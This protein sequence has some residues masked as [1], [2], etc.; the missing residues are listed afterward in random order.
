[1]RHLVASAA[2]VG[3]ILSLVVH[4]SALLGVVL[5]SNIAPVWLLH[6]GIFVVFIPFVFS[7]RAVLGSRPSLAKVRALFPAWVVALGVVVF[8][9]AAVNFLLFVLHT[10]GGSPSIRDG[11]YI[12]QSHGH[13]IR[14]IS[15]AEYAAF[16]ANE[17]RGFSGHW[18]AF[19]YAPFAYF[20]FLKRPNHSVK[21]TA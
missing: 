21:R 4:I 12:L 1:M 14:E 16:K 6:V 11:K 8:A 13:L 3:F 20:M 2:L 18:L 9:Y 15:S 5:S 19:Y 7:S 10:E 17:V